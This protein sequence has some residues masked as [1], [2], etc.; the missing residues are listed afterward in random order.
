MLIK[1]ELIARFG[2]YVIVRQWL[3]GRQERSYFEDQNFLP[4]E[5]E[6]IESLRG[7]E[8]QAILRIPE[9]IFDGKPS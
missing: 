5:Y 3:M 7:Q 8:T 4:L 1:Q 2:T 6:Y 9:E